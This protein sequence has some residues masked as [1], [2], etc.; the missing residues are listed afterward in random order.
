MTDHRSFEDRVAVELGQMAGPEP[1]VDA[2]AVARSVAAQA[3]KRRFAPMFSAL[4]FV[5]GGAALALIVGLVASGVLDVRDDS[6][7]ANVVSPVPSYSFKAVGPGAEDFSPRG[8]AQLDATIAVSALGESDDMIVWS[9][10]DSGAT[11]SQ[12][13]VGQY[14]RRIVAFDDRFVAVGEA[15]FSDSRSDGPRTAAEIWTSPDG[16][17]WG[18]VASLENADIHELS[19][20]DGELVAVGMDH[21]PEDMA[22]TFPRGTPTIWTSADAVAWDATGIAPVTEDHPEFTPGDDLVPFFLYP[23]VKSDDGI[24]L[25]RGWYQGEDDIE[26]LWRSEDGS[27][28]EEVDLDV[29]AVEL[30][31]RTPSGFVMN[32][33]REVGEDEFVIEALT[34]TDGLSW[35]AAAELGE[36]PSEAQTFVTDSA[37]PV[38]FELALDPESPEIA[39]PMAPSYR[40]VNGSWQPFESGIDTAAITRSAM[41]TDGATMLL[42]GRDLAACETT[43]CLWEPGGDVLTVWVGTPQ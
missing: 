38:R 35:E 40:F 3:P 22:G 32:V 14:L 28:W 5:A 17:A 13:P 33:F 27:A 7:P 36:S 6:D 30:L 20:I 11:W 10:A 18:Q 1:H 23:A 39:D 29:G 25:V 19:V 37:G 15:N 16:V 21:R 9:S 12:T 41:A 2:L 43:D 8:I 42:A 4:K 24:W 31:A 34:S 26:V